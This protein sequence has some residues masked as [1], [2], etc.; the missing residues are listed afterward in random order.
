MIAELDSEA[1]RQIVVG[2]DASLGAQ[3]IPTLA[4]VLRVAAGAGPGAA[5]S[6]GCRPAR[7]P[8]SSRLSG[9]WALGGR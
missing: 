5:R 8:E 3:T 2:T 7:R 6:E 1:L 9:R 4:E